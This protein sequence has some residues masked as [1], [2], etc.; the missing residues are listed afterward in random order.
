VHD[1]EIF[2]GV[3]GGLLPRFEGASKDFQP[4]AEE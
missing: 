2:V 3:L 4:L 1:A